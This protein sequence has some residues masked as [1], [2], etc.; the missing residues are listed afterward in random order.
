MT[1]WVVV[2][3]V[4][5]A[6]GLSGTAEGLDSYQ[7]DAS[8]EL[9]SVEDTTT[10]MDVSLKTIGYR[11]YFAQV[12]G[13]E[14]P[15]ELQPFRQRASWA[16]ASFAF[17]EEQISTDGASGLEIGA[18]YV[19]PD[20]AVGVDVSYESGE[21][22][23]TD[24]YSDLRLGAVVWLNDDSNLAIEAGIAF[25]DVGGTTDT[26]T[27]DLGAR[28]IMPIGDMALE[29]KG[30]Y[31]SINIDTPGAPDVNGFEVETRYFFMDELYAGFSF[32]TVDIDGAAD[33]SNYAI[34]A[35]YVFPFGLDVGL[36]FGE[37]GVPRSLVFPAGDDDVFAIEVG[38]RF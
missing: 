25:G 21:T 17:G 23:T 12:D 20:S 33:T 19:I 36:R 38:Y 32:S 14:G 37:G 27:L 1:R 31:R 35:G 9:L 22:D 2:A 15:I 6:L 29:I 30:G 16:E 3:G 26:T 18:R 10:P 8:F 11:W 28:Y 24:L 7:S 4:L 5:L 13:M 34:T